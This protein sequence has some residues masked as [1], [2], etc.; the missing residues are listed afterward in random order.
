[1]CSRVMDLLSGSDW[2]AFLSI[3]G[4]LARMVG[5][6]ISVFPNRGQLPGSEWV[7]A[8]CDPAVQAVVFQ[9]S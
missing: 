3:P 4:M 7:L 8:S 6:F 2:A 1:M 5:T 9:G